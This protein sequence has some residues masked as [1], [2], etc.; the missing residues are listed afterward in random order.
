MPKLPNQFSVLESRMVGHVPVPP[1]NHE[2]SISSVIA[3]TGCSY[4]TCN[5]PTLIPPVMQSQVPAQ[6]THGRKKITAQNKVL[7]SVEGHVIE[8]NAQ[9][10]DHRWMFTVVVE[11]Y[12]LWWAVPLL[13]CG[14]QMELVR[15]TLPSP[16]IPEDVGTTPVAHSVTYYLLAS[17]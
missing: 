14:I 10:P 3:R 16:G 9:G 11:D 7:I 8:Q 6:D 17:T 4:A 2:K 1:V 15:G 12:P 5:L 13:S